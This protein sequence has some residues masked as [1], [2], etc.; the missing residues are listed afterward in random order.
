[1]L[2]WGAIQIVAL[3][4]RD[5]DGISYL[6]HDVFILYE[7]AYVMTKSGCPTPLLVDTV[8]DSRISICSVP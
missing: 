4:S 5:M 1:M 3:N 2:Y 7:M 8:L 6:H